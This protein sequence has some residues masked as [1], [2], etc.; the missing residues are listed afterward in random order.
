LTAVDAGETANVVVKL[1]ARPSGFGAL[2][3]HSTGPNGTTALVPA[4][5]SI[6]PQVIIQS[7]PAVVP[8]GVPVSER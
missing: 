6:L 8:V 2:L 7:I 5:V 4:I 3:G 1:P